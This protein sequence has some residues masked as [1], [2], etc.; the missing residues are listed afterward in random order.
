MA[1][2]QASRV[3]LL[4]AMAKPG[5]NFDPPREQLV[6]HDAEFLRERRF[7]EIFATKFWDPGHASPLVCVP[8]VLLVLSW[9]WRRALFSCKHLNPLALCALSAG[10][11]R[12]CNTRLT[13][14]PMGPFSV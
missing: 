1:L 6:P 7:D 9:S 4:R 12:E 14:Q 2:E 13:A 3:T 11:P 5:F 10:Q 8:C